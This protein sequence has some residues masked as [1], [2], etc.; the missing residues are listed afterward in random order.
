MRD[1]AV[2]KGDRRDFSSEIKHKKYKIAPE[3]GKV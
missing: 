1:F 2:V 3:W